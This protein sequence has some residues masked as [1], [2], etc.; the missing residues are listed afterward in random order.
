MRFKQVFHSVP[1]LGDAFTAH[2]V[3]LQYCAAAGHAIYCIHNF[4][5]KRR[6]LEHDG[7]MQ[8]EGNIEEQQGGLKTLTM[9]VGLWTAWYIT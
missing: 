2:R 6:C 8:A 9:P 7:R 1:K 3:T 4:I 5:K